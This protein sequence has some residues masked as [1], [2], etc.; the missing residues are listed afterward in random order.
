[1]VQRVKADPRGRA[2]E[3][4]CLRPLACGDCEFEYRRRHGCLSLVCVVCCQMDVSANGRALARRS[5]A[6]CG[7]SECDLLT[8]TMRRPRPTRAVET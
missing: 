7:V 1:M 8:S 4:V 3:G 6:E 2:V 5:P